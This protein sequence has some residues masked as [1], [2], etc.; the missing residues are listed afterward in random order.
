MIN[1][2]AKASIPYIPGIN[3]S[4]RVFTSAS[5]IELTELPK[6]LV[7][8]GGGYVALE[9]A[10]MYAQFCSEVTLLGKSPVFLPNE[11][12]DMSDAIRALLSDKGIR[13][14]TGVTIDRIEKENDQHD[15]VV[16]RNQQGGIEAVLAA[17]I[18]V[19][20]GRQPYTEG[21]NLS[22]A[23]I[24]QDE[25]GFIRVNERLQT[26]RPHIWAIGDV[27]GGPQFTYISLDDFR[28]IKS[29]FFGHKEHT[30]RDRKNIASSLFITPPFSHVGLREWEAL[31]KGYQINVA[32]LPVATNI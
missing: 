15:S 5:L 4:R 6:E 23:G 30:S 12:R 11:D 18:L 28:I 25:R 2:G 32:T 24:K 31:E 10:S 9:F 27:N 22:A 17:A 19:A 3:D 21:L 13:I 1:T 14:E 16:F 29:Q 26:N 20:V 7:I 8:I